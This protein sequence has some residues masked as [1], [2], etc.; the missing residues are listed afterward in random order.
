MIVI[1]SRCRHWS[2]SSLVSPNG[3]NRDVPLTAEGAPRLAG[4]RRESRPETES[5][6]PR[7]MYSVGCPRTGQAGRSLQVQTTADQTWHC[8]RRCPVRLLVDKRGEVKKVTPPP[9]TVRDCCT[10]ERTRGN[11]GGYCRR[12]VTERWAPV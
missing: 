9:E 4:L 2:S 5:S 10:F 6:L 1:Y 3:R 8:G 7:R 11:L 12:D